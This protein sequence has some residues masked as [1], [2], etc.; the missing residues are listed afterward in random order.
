MK[1]L[2]SI[3][4]FLALMTAVTA[5]ASNVYVP[6][7]AYKGKTIFIVKIVCTGTSDGAAT[8]ALSITAA[9][10]PEIFDMIQETW[11]VSATTMKGGT[12]PDAADLTVQQQI[13]GSAAVVEMFGTNGVNAI[14]A[15]ATYTVY[16]I[17]TS[18]TSANGYWPITG[19][20]IV[21]VENQT[22]AGGITNI[23]LVFSK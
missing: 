20:L 16:P 4:V 1:R 2:F 18:G 17:Y 3:I 21:D 12:A 23:Y 7:I 6:S 15:S 10:Y 11:L 8:D 14:H 19:A 22:S 13:G 9:A 5:Q